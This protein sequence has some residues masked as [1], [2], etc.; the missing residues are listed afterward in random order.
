MR[1][2]LTIELNEVL[3]PKALV[4][5]KLTL[6]SQ[7]M[8][9]EVIV[10]D[11]NRATGVMYLDRGTG[12]TR[13]VRSRAVVVAGGTLESTRL[14]L[15][16]NSGRF[17]TGIANSSGVLGKNFMEHM[18]G[19]V[20]GYFPQLE[21]AKP[22]NEDGIFSGH[23]FIPWWGHNRKN[24]HL[25]G[26]HVEMGGGSQM[27]PG[28]A[29]GTEGFGSGFK[30]KV[31]AMNPAVFGLGTHGEMLPNSQTYVELDRDVK[32]NWEFRY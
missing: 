15:Y 24:S 12:Q 31:R 21:G 22:L 7:S 11:E 13:E 4:T 3:V 14:L 18:G 27:F 1:N 20:S 29:Y 5:G 16:S 32:D 9:V 28:H 30:K 25:R 6:L 23:A 8:A 19:S 17:P 26:Y 2:R 10:N